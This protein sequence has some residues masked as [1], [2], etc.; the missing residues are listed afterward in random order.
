MS[1]KIKAKKRVITF[2]SKI[3]TKRKKRIEN[4]LL[5]LKNEPVP[6]KSADVAKLKGFDN[7]YRIRIGKLRIVYEVKWKEKIILIHRIS[8]R[9]DAY[10]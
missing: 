9:K 6:V 7:V 2:V 10:K 8:Y 4:L 3:P 1:F 5:L